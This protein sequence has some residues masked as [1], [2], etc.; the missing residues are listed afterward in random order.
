MRIRKGNKMEPRNNLLLPCLV[1]GEERNYGQEIRVCFGV[2][3]ILSASAH[4]I[5]VCSRCFVCK[6]KRIDQVTKHI[7]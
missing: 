2:W 3:L 1:Q 4:S 7:S 6:V 5:L